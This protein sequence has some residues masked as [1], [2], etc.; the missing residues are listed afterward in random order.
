MDG[1]SVSLIADINLLIRI[2]ENPPE[3]DESAVG[4]INRPLLLCQTKFDRAV[5]PPISSKNLQKLDKRPAGRVGC[6][7]KLIDLALPICKI[8]LSHPTIAV[9]EE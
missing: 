8:E 6:V 5:L 1:H 2:V 3:A 9:I 4:A 7:G